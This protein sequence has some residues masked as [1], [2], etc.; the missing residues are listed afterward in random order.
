MIQFESLKRPLSFDE[1]LKIQANRV[2][3][4]IADEI[5]D[6]VLFF[7]HTPVITRG[8]GLQK[9]AL[10]LS[11]DKQTRASSQAIA[12]DRSALPEG[13]DF[14][15]CDRGGDLT[16]HGPGQLVIYPIFKLD[17]STSFTRRHDVGHFIRET[18]QVVIRFLGGLGITAAHVPDATG[19]WVNNGSK[20]IASMGIAVKKWVT[21]HGIAINITN[22]LSPY[23]LISPCGFEPEVMT[24]LKDLSPNDAATIDSRW[25]RECEIRLI[26]AFVASHIPQH[27]AATPPAT[28]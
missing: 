8:R 14:V 10:A 9:P 18:E 3:A 25:R 5:G 11:D 16:Y 28:L 7:E 26:Q 21:S 17:G 15:E 2:R 23:R 20:K 12:L 1:G 22:D 24:R 4:R 27:P 6:T 13:I 19:V